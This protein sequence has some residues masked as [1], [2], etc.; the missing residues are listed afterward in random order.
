M[1]K[2]Q[3]IHVSH[4]E[5]IVQRYEWLLGWA[6]ELS[7]GDRHQAEDLV[8]EAFVHFTIDRPDL[9]AV[10]QNLE[11]YLYAMLRNM[12]ISG[13]RRTVRQQNAY[14][15]L[16]QLNGPEPESLE[17]ELRTVEER[18]L[19][20]QDRLRRICE[21]AC[22]RKETS[23]AGSV[24]ILRFFLGYYPAEIAEIL[25]ISRGAVNEWLRASRAE[26]KLYLVDPGS[27]AFMTKDRR[28]KP[29]FSKSELVA[30]DLV[31]EL[32]NA[33]FCSHGQGCLTRDEHEDLYQHSNERQIVSSVLSH[34]VSCR[35]CLD[36]VNDLLG[37]P[38]LASRYPTKMLGK[39]TRP[40]NNNGGGQSGRGGR[41]ASTGDGLL[42]RS[43]R[44]LKKTIEHHPQTLLVA[45]NGFVIGSQKL[46]LRSNELVISVNIEEKIGFVEIF[47]DQ[48]VRM[49]F[50]TVAAPP[51]GTIEHRKRIALSDGRSLELSLSFS[52]PWPT[53][54]VVY[55]DPSTQENGAYLPKMLARAEPRAVKD[56]NE[57][58]VS[59]SGL[60]KSKMGQ[61]RALLRDWSL[62]LRPGV[63][64]LVLAILALAVGLIIWRSPRPLVSAATLLQRSAVAEQAQAARTDQVLHRTIDL[65]ERRADGGGLIA[66]RK[67]EVW[68]S[69][70]MGIKAVRVYD[71]KGHLIAGEWR[72]NDGTR[73]V[74]HHQVQPKSQVPRGVGSPET[75]PLT[76][77]NIW[78][79][80]LSAKQFSSLTSNS[81]NTTLL[82]VNEQPTTYLITY[83]GDAG[84]LQGVIK[85]TLTLS[86]SDLHAVGQK[87]FIKRGDEVREYR[88]TEASLEGRAP[89][90]VAPSVFQPESQLLSLAQPDISTPRPDRLTSVPA[91]RPSTAT[92]SAEV[93]MEVLRLLSEAGA[94]LG[95]QISVT[96][97]PEGPL[98]VQ[99]IVDTKDRKAE[100]LRALHS[101]GN[102]PAVQI[103]VST[104]AEALRRRR[105]PASGESN[106]AI[107]ERV[108]GST[109]KILVDPDLRRYLLS[110]GTSANQ[111]EEEISR[112]ARRAMGQS[113]DAMQHAWALKRLAE[114]FSA[115]DLRTLSPEARSKW[116][117]MIRQH[118][119]I[120]EHG[121]ASLRADISGIFPEVSSA[122]V[123]GS[124]VDPSDQ[125]LKQA[126]LRLFEL[127]SAQEQAIR[128]A[129][130]VAPTSSK[131]A[132]VRSVQFWL[133]LR[134]AEKLAGKISRL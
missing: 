87:L 129:F 119:Q 47:S 90:A 31:Q 84:R 113:L 30:E 38:P 48:D 35:E 133:S 6:L 116:L 122:E 54:R 112:I 23:K 61:L 66:H 24:L 52:G 32:H 68:Q 103:D 67:L 63:V 27:L 4:E 120:L 104:V 57:T 26:A 25:R 5:V 98:V 126:L 43:R 50:S 125:D 121:L 72:R 58:G 123:G 118:A 86:R 60:I 127:C 11:G 95:E 9:A 91:Y 79:L 17:D 40:P 28:R 14:S 89:D 107:I 10:S 132:A 92:A 13:I 49:L 53:L 97:A 62:W 96:R 34:L 124:S 134:S 42:D 82:S 101:I 106:S 37:L 70:A 21:Y 93:E 114:R 16:A 130:A 46:G 39:D 41:G 110:K 15:S 85:A 69:A 131:V 55:F 77:E 108:E 1:H 128:S 2:A 83:A 29:S 18:E 12:H 59:I 22:I 33:I 75:V 78:Q 20:V 81:G 71:D 115:E 109:A 36:S 99:G 100:I 19:E 88:F 65:E 76:L 94:D 51:E 80:D 8:H 64:M 44:R 74:Y 7:N 45:V 3:T 102:N 105:S 56:S 73:T 117:S 111:I